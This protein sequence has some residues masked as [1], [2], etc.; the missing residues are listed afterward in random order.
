VVYGHNGSGKLI[1]AR[2]VHGQI[3][4][5][6]EFLRAVDGEHFQRMCAATDTDQAVL[7]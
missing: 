5:C 7:P 3:R 2:A 4:W 1:D 6:T